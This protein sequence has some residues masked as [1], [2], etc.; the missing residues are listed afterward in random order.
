M[1]GAQGSLPTPVRE[2]ARFVLE[3]GFEVQREIYDGSFNS[4]F[5]L[6]RGPCTVTIIQDRG[7]WHIDVGR[8][9][10]QV[11][12]ADWQRR[13]G[14][15]LACGSD[16]VDEEAAFYRRHWTQIVGIIAEQSQFSSLPVHSVGIAPDRLDAIMADFEARKKKTQGR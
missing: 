10:E 2:F 11:R 9:G 13:I 15:V 6:T 5:S 7:R 4:L 8:D 3:S 16:N 12:F 1:S 14:G